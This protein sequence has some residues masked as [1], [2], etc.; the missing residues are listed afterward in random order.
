MIN[1]IILYDNIENCITCNT[2]LKPSMNSFNLQKCQLHDNYNT[3]FMLYKCEKCL[4]KYTISM[5]LFKCIV[6]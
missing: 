3:V 2:K 1:F 4:C 5:T 6:D